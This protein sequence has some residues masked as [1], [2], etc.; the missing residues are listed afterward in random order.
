MSLPI[1]AYRVGGYVRDT[2]LGLNPKDR[3]W[4]I[5]GHTEEEV[6][7]LG[8]T[9]VSANFPVF[10]H[11]ETKEEYALARTERKTE[12]GYQG[13]QVSA[14]PEV[15]LEEDL[16]RRD[17]TINAIA[18]TSNGELID[19][20]GGQADLEAGLL[21]HVTE[22]FSED[23][24]R[25][26]RVA[27]F[28][29]RY[30]YTIAPK[31]MTLMKD[32]VQRG[33]VDALTPERV[34]AELWKA[35]SELQ[36]SPFFRTLHDC[37]ALARLFPELAILDGVPQR[38]T[39]HPEIDTFVH[40]MMVVD[41]AA[42]LTSDPMTRFAAL[43]HDLGKGVTPR[44]Q[45]PRHHNHE[46]LGVPL[47]HALCDRLKS[48]KEYRQL[49]VLVSQLHL[50]AHR[51]LELRSNTVLKI[52]ERLDAFR[53]PGRLDRFLMACEADFR[54]RLG[55]E[56]RDYPQLNYLR[57]CFGAACTVS[58]SDILAQGVTGARVGEGLRMKRIL[59]VKGI[60]NRWRKECP[61]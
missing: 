53:N 1:N 31:T 7:A 29:A 20:Y 21:R 51:A 24:V 17:L 25:I 60:K 34:W 52:F 55:F 14:Q 32:M 58:P 13:F 48:P 44:E 6:L 27:R 43:V 23:P 18:M 49:G 12:L 36:P 9:R 61:M 46:N 39:Y 15:T 2:L 57:E 50:D 54:G 56:D 11:P 38:A 30:G 41:M 5:V 19:P 59:A 42:Q 28:A 10:L 8:F 22:A 4:V 40:V 16:A 37:G 47:V 45:W 26:L 3:D 33:E 35:L